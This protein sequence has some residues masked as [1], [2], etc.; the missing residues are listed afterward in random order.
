[1]LNHPQILHRMLK[2]LKIF[3][4]IVMAVILTV[5]SLFICI[6]S[7]LSP[8]HLT[9]I[10]NREANRM[11]D[12]NVTIGRVELGIKGTFP[13]VTLQ[14][15]S[16]TVLSNSLKNIDNIDNMPLW[17]DSLLTLESFKGGINIASLVTG[18]IDLYDVE[19]VRPEINLLTVNDSVSNYL[20][21]PSD[22]DE[23]SSD[24][25][26]KLPK[27]SINRFNIT[28]PKPLR[29]RNLHTGQHFTLSLD[30][31]SITEQDSPTYS[32]NVGGDFDYPELSVYNL[33]KMSF[34]LDGKLSWDPE[35]PTEIEIS[36]FRLQSDAIDARVS[37]K[38]DIA[39]DII[40]KDFSFYIYDTPVERVIRMIPD[41]IQ[42]EYNL[43]PSHFST[44][45]AVSL[46]VKST[47]P[48]NL[49]TDSIP[50]AEIELEIIP[51]K[52]RYDKFAFNKVGGKLFAFLRGNNLE[53]ATFK[54]ENLNVAG[55][56]TDL[57]FN[58]E[59]SSIFSD[60]LITG[61]IKGRT[62]LSKLPTQI[63]QL[64]N[65]SVKGRITADI[66]FKARQSMLTPDK[67]HQISVNG[68][69]DAYN[70]YYLSADTNNLVNASHAN[71]KFGTHTLI[72]SNET[73][74]SD[75]MLTARISIDSAT[76]LHTEY[77]MKIADVS[78]AVGVL[79]QKESRDTTLVLP[80]GGRLDLGKFY[81]TV[82]G[83]SIVLNLQNTSGHVT[84]RRF[85][86]MKRVPEFLADLNIKRLSTGSPDTRFL[87]SGA[88]F[89]VTAHKLPKKRMSRQVRKTID[90][91][92]TSFPQMP[93]DSVYKRAI[94]I[95]R[96]K[97][98]H[99]RPPRI[100]PEYTAEETEIIDW[101]T[102][103][104]IRRLL[105]EW[106]VKGSLTAR[107]AGLFTPFFPIRNRVR[108]FNIE[109]NN[110]SINLN[111]VEFKAGKS[112]FLLSGIISNLKRGLTSKG[113]R[114]PLKL[115]FEMLSDTI[116]INELADAT[117][118]GSAYATKTIEN[119]KREHFALNID[120]IE[121]HEE[122]SDADF[123]K[124]MGKIVANSPDEMAPLMVPVNIDL[125]LTTRS[126][127]IMYSDMDLKDFYGEVLVSQ[128]G[129]NL[130]DLKAKSEFGSVGLS[131]LYSS[132][133]ANDIRFG[134]GMQVNDFNIHRFT[135]LVPALDSIMP[136]LKDI[137]G[138]IDAQ[139]AA[140]CQIDSAMNIELPT[141]EAAVKIEGDSLQLIDKETY[142]KIGKWL[143]FK[144]KQDNIIKHMN[145]ELMVKDN[146]MTLYPFMFDIDRYKLGVQGYNDLSLNFDYH[147]A[148]LKSPLPFKFGINLKG[149][150][151]NYKIRLGRARFNEKS[152]GQSVAIVD[153]AR[154][155]LLSQIENVFRRGVNNSRFAKLNISNVPEAEKIDL[156][157][158]TI[159]SADSLLFIQQGLIPAPEPIHVDS[160]NI[161]KSSKRSGKEAGI[162]ILVA[163]LLSLF[164][165][166]K[167]KKTK[168]EN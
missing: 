166:K 69:I 16:I 66:D 161:K 138:I 164:C 28:E 102:S 34:G 156:S 25:D 44:D 106:D 87:L 81:M 101:G 134:F 163:I 54:A 93:I 36:N 53:K 157:Q 72:K 80:M 14:I 67:F 3:A 17:A 55:V 137:D 133:S 150:P 29:F 123:E 22:D 115:N 98:L 122:L 145:V 108:H 131:A 77:S 43:T 21:Y 49:T 140:T 109:F 162:G 147:I 5:I 46:G 105:L 47:G 19:F 63:E 149:D 58:I 99:K 124:E 42:K 91:L 168:N 158:D 18:K 40:V 8:E 71:L 95:Q 57:L 110:D 75:S 41:S 132:P 6:S 35:T 116:D 84:M 104:F 107:R 159:S 112:D 125:N 155:N 118:R 24:S 39:K 100:H 27:I 154:I 23:V 70:V 148:V 152:V 97:H 96:E 103:D 136:L 135:S 11:L 117:F 15:D 38:A 78:L 141:L 85:K 92:R 126:Q 2:F 62:E 61:T 89:N 9:K 88:K 146:L 20:I 56:A 52:L 73:A 130:N 151:D 94:E 128:G 50:S 111:N 83:D 68:Q 64:I 1:M 4:W 139:I 10:A 165:F 76:V 114:S 127:N 79:N 60:P 129:L 51:G 37:A 32:I 13:L 119:G 120:S 160:P 82:L 167:F 65:G 142:R 30:G 33:D 144:D 7:L 121:S 26:T 86:G 113:F 12:A 59:A 31:L 153:T 143:L 45:I 90:S 48:F 74:K